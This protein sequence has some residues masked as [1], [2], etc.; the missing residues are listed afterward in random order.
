MREVLLYTDVTDKEIEGLR[1]YITC[2]NNTA[3]RK[4]V[5]PGLGHAVLIT[6]LCWSILGE[7]KEKSPWIK[8]E[9]RT[10]LGN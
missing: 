7:G 3:G 1:C 4:V 2:P 9:V 6:R 5:V 10:W 8:E